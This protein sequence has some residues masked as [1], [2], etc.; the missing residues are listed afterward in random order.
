MLRAIGIKNNEWNREEQESYEVEL[1]TI[2][3][4]YHF[5][6]YNY[7]TIKTLSFSGNLEAG[8]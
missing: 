8:E 2:D 4:L 7:A 3:D 5:I 1:Q 6:N